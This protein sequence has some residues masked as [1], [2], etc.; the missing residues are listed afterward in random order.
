MNDEFKHLGKDHENAMLKKEKRKLKKKMMFGMLFD[1]DD[2][3]E[4]E[5]TLVLPDAVGH[6]NA[7]QQER[8]QSINRL[9][10]NP[11]S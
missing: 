4:M 11:A 10:H 8:Q 6:I 2:S 3:S 5:P 7:T 1:S 9:L